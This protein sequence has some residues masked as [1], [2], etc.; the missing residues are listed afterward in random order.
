MQQVLVILV[1]TA[2]MPHAWAAQ[3]DAP[4]FDRYSARVTG[5]RVHV[6]G[7]PGENFSS[8]TQLDVDDTVWVVGVKGLWA[9]IEV[10]GGCF[11]YVSR[12]LVTVAGEKGSVNAD[13][14]NLRARPEPKADV[15]G[16]VNTGDEV[17]IVE[18]RG[19]WLGLR[20]PTA[21]R[22]WILARYL[23]PPPPGA[24]IEK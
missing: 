24:T 19:K 14:V 17:E 22:A 11:V 8:L 7:G 12:S 10:P 1:L 21:A 4:A 23:E 13:R 20:P 6:R 16:Q 9:Q 2:T 15:L 5:N 3:G 18:T